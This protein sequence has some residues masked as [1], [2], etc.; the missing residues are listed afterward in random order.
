LSKHLQ[1]AIKSRY[2]ST[3]AREVLGMS[4]KDI[5][6]LFTGY[7]SINR[8]LVSLK[9]LISNDEKYARLADNPFLN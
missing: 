1:T 2:F 4:D 7:K 5:A 6:D 9:Y 8:Q 3:Y